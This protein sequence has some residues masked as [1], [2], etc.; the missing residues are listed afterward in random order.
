MVFWVDTT[1]TCQY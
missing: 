1:Q